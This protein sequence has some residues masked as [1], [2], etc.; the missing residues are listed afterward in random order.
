MPPTIRARRPMAAGTKTRGRLK[1]DDSNTDLQPATTQAA[2][3]ECEKRTLRWGLECVEILHDGECSRQARPY[4]GFPSA[5]ID[6]L[7]R[8]YVHRC[9][10]GPCIRGS[11]G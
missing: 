3:C 4:C 11:V 1:N 2:S 9:R 10:G 6:G 5:S 7:A 8:P